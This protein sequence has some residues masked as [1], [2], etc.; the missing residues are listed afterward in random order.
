MKTSETTQAVGNPKASS[1]VMPWDLGQE[2]DPWLTCPVRSTV[3]CHGQVGRVVDSWARVRLVEFEDGSIEEASLADCREILAYQW[4][5]LMKR[6][7]VK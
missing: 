2:A 7:E 6:L 4:K 3:V 1:V 5:S